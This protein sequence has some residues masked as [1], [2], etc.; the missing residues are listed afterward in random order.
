MRHLNV[1]L[2]IARSDES[3]NL[4]AKTHEGPVKVLTLPS[5]LAERAPSRETLDPFVG[6]LL[7]EALLPDLSLEHFSYLKEAPES[8]AAL[9]RHL[10]AVK[11][12]DV[13]LE[14]FG[15]EPKKRK[16]QVT[17]PPISS[18]LTFQGSNTSYSLLSALSFGNS[19]KI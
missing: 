4:F 1:K 2:F 19:V 11:L 16:H 18:I 7:I 15:Y 8:L 6:R 14:A 12:N 5:L 10:R 13:S 9:E 3:A 17:Y